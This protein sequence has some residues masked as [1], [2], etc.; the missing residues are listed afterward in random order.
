MKK[1]LDTIFFKRDYPFLTRQIEEFSSLNKAISVTNN[2]PLMATAF[3]KLQPFIQNRIKLFVGADKEMH[4]ERMVKYLAE[5][6]IFM[7]FDKSECA[8]GDLFLDCGADLI[9]KGHPKAITELTQTGSMQY[10]Q[11]KSH[12]PIVSIDESK[13]KLLEDYYGTADGFIRAIKEKICDNL[14][15]KHFIIVGYGKIG[16]GI[17]RRLNQEKAKITAIDLHLDENSDFANYQN[18]ELLHPSEKEGIKKAI[19][20][21]YCLVTCTGVKNLMSQAPYAEDLL[22]SVVVLAN[23]GAEDEFGDKFPT[24]RV[25]NNKF[26][27]NFL[28][29]YPTLLRYLDPV[30]YAHN[31]LFRLFQEGKL[32]PGFQ[33]FP[34]ELSDDILNEWS[35]YWQEDISDISKL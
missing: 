32:K 25:L 28:L 12:V 8:R 21:A 20:T 6:N 29:E 2:T 27:A 1:E 4:D 23:M 34:K 15:D 35:N 11:I 14:K 31:S 22:N 10:K 24:K 33:P 16:K 26:A 19:K 30:F 5:Q 18:V 17:A 7:S 9:Q 13:V 3:I